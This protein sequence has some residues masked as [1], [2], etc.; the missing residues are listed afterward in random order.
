MMETI[1]NQGPREHFFGL[2]DSLLVEEVRCCIWDKQYGVLVD[3]E[4]T[5]VILMEEILNTRIDSS[6]N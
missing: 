1:G 6:M 4:Q 2:V 5:L 3:T